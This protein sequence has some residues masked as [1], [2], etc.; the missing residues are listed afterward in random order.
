[1]ISLDQVFLLEQKVES[2]VEKIQQLQAENDALRNKCA[3]L[4]NALSA[5]SEQLN[6]F[7][8]D[9]NQIENGIKKALD[10]LNSIE[11]SVLKT[12]SSMAS[13]GQV[14]SSTVTQA[15]TQQVA[16][17]VKTVQTPTPS[18]VIIQHNTQQVQ[19]STPVQPQQTVKAPVETPVVEPSFEETPV[20]ETVP[21]FAENPVQDFSPSFDT[22]TEMPQTKPS[23]E[24]EIESEL[25]VNTDIPNEEEENQDDLGF[26]IF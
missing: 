26:D 4:T 2:A 7:E 11:N 12:V 8:T 3:E 5:K 10:R 25:D 24:D 9:Q 15:R 20:V 16:Q 6:T 13:S 18:A 23:I 17:P 22:M 1:M 21:S 19:A 14:A